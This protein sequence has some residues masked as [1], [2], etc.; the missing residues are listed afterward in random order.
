MDHD[1]AQSRALALYAEIQEWIAE[2][3]TRSTEIVGPVPCFFARLSGWY[4]W[5]LILRG[6]DPARLL[7]GRQ[8]RDWRIEVNPPSLL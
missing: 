2:S 3:G 8:L 4:R 7:L 5:Q 1:K 6:P